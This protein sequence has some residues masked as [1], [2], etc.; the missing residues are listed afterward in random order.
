MKKVSKITHF[1]DPLKA[2]VKEWEEQ[3][4]RQRE[5]EQLDASLYRS[6]SRQHGLGLTEDEQEERA[7]RRCFPLF[8]QVLAVPQHS[9][10]WFT[11][12]LLPLMNI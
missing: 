4:Q 1:H 8:N 3:E 9:L 2:L 6:R 5:Q 10:L 12:K 7:F 11:Q